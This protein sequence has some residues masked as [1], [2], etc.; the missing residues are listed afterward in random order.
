MISTFNFREKNQLILQMCAAVKAFKMKLKL[1]RNQLSKGEMCHFPT[2][3][4]RIPQHKH[5]ELGEK[6]AKRMNLLT[7]EFDRRLILSKDDDIQLKLI[8]DPFSVD[9]E[10]VPG[11][12]QLEVNELQSSAIYRNKHRES[13]LWDFYKSLDD[14]KYKNLIEVALKTFSIFGSTYICEQ[15]FSIMNMNKNKQR[16]SLTDDHLED[17]MKISH[18]KYDPR[19]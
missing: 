7:E 18:F 13:S 19:I 1:F 5:A 6:Y 10:E 17:I 4:Q 9:P 12:L 8:E 16:S 14:E 15:T 3:A 2:C 11:D